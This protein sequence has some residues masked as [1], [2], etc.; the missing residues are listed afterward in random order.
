MGGAAATRPRV[1]CPW[2][3]REWVALPQ[4]HLPPAAH[5]VDERD[6]LDS[7]ALRSPLELFHEGAPLPR[8]APPSRA[9][10]L[11]RAAPRRAA[12]H[13]IYPNHAVPLLSPPPRGLQVAGGPSS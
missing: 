1:A 2:Q 4:L 13:A 12:P 5:G 10:P 3:L 7:V 6:W 8:T 9:A 11:S